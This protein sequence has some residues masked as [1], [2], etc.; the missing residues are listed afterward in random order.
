MNSKHREM[1]LTKF[2]KKTKLNLQKMAK[3]I[4]FTLNLFIACL[5]MIGGG[6]HWSRSGN[7]VSTVDQTTIKTNNVQIELKGE[8]YF[9][10]Q[11]EIEKFYITDAIPDID[12]LPSTGAIDYF[13]EMSG[14]RHTKNKA[15]TLYNT[16]SSPFIIKQMSGNVKR[17]QINIQVRCYKKLDTSDIKSIQTLKDADATSIYGLS[18]SS[19]PLIIA[20]K[21]RLSTR[22][23]LFKDNTH[24]LQTS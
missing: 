14:S 2:Y 16:K 7:Y 11:I 20:T 9:E 21:K 22:I 6:H 17:Q 15:S 3:T 10:I 19:N 13:Y 1:R 23:H 12:P 5:Q 24:Y 8:G 4:L 18:H